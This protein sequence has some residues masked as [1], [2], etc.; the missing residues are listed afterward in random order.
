MTLSLSLSR[1]M[2]VMTLSRSMKVMTL[3][4]SPSFYESDEHHECNA[5]SHGDQLHQRLQQPRVA[6]QQLR[7]HGDCRYVNETPR[8]EGEDPHSGGGR[9]CPSLHEEPAG[10]A[11]HGPNSRPELEKHSPSLR[12][13]GLDQ[14]GEVSDLVGDL[15]DEDG[16]GGDKPHPPAGQV[17]GTDGQ[18]IREVVGEVCGK[19]EVGGDFDGLCP[20][21]GGGVSHAHCC[22]W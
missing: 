7:Y 3:S 17:G 2:K 19:V 8:G 9:P 18:P 16:E 22:C 1:S 11:R 13:A 4:L 14:D 15:V 20:G 6:L 10:S 12:E 5:H 21:G